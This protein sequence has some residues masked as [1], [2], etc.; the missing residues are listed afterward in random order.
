MNE[1]V[2]GAVRLG[3]SPYFLRVSAAVRPSLIL[4]ETFTVT[5]AS[6]GSESFYTAIETNAEDGNLAMYN[7]MRERDFDDELFSPGS[8]Y[9]NYQI[10]MMKIESITEV[11][12]PQLRPTPLPHTQKDD[13]MM[14]SP[15]IL[16]SYEWDALFTIAGIVVGAYKIED[17]YAV[18][19]L[20]DFDF[21]EL[22]S[23]DFAIPEM[24]S[25]F[26]LAAKAKGVK[27]AIIDVSGN[28]GG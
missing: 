15:G 10:A 19:K 20:Q 9:Q 28:G 6:G 23:G 22:E 4:P 25:N 13:S 2:K 21:E 1:L 24:W 11:P 12:A 14:T 18:F 5:Y 27:T 3:P 16:G 17:T 8:A 26:T 7:L